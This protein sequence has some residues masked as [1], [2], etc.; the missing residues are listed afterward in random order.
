MQVQTPIMD[1]FVMGAGSR[2]S[3]GAFEPS[4]GHCRFQLK[5]R[6]FPCSRSHP[7]F[8]DGIQGP[9]PAPDGVAT[10]EPSG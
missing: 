6:R 4:D 2:Y 1:T 5:A 3:S 9:L 10:P 8:P 7:A